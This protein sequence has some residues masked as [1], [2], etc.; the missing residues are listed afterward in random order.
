MT[1]NINP[2]DY[3]FYCK[4]DIGSVI[5]T[6]VELEQASINEFNIKMTS[7]YIEQ[8]NCKK[9]NSDK[10]EHVFHYNKV[11]ASQFEIYIFNSI[12]SIEKGFM[13]KDLLRLFRK[14]KKKDEYC[15]LYILKKCNNRLHVQINNNNSKHYYI[16]LYDISYD[17]VQIN[18]NDYKNRPINV[19][20]SKFI[21]FCKGCKQISPN[22][23]IIRRGNICDFICKEN[24][25]EY[26]E[27][28]GSNIVDDDTEIFNYN[29]DTKTIVSI[30]KISNL[31][32]SF[33]IYIDNGKPIIF[34]YLINGLGDGMI[35]VHSN[36]Y[37]DDEIEK[38]D[39]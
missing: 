34:K 8:Q 38:L 22:I 12:N 19:K 35:V 2:D 3:L 31:S 33:Q 6:W 7:D 36:E 14:I 20:S 29:F 11:Y 10:V 21:N 25:M 39:N 5:K 28:F 32:I 17:N 15:I 13:T 24:T 18:I 26:S 4:T 1:N 23:N 37:I 16:T 27:M 30:Q 9:D